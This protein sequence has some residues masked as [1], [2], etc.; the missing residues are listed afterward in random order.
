VLGVLAIAPR[1]Y[2]G[3]CLLEQRRVPGRITTG[4]TRAGR[5]PDRQPPHRHPR[6]R[7]RLLQLPPPPAEEKHHRDVPGAVL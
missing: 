3:R 6:R 4:V 7:H 2:L 5:R 1:V